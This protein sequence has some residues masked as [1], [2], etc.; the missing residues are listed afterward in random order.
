MLWLDNSSTVSS[1][2]VILLRTFFVGFGFLAPAMLFVKPKKMPQLK[3]LFVAAGIQIVRIAG[4]LYALFWILDAYTATTAKPAGDYLI[5]SGPK[6]YLGE[7]FY[8]YWLTPL[9]FFIATQLL[10][11]PKIKQNKIAVSVIALLVLLNSFNVFPI[12][13]SQ[14]KINMPWVWGWPAPDSWMFAVALLLHLFM[15]TTIV[16]TVLVA[17]GKL[18]EEGNK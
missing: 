6:L 3:K 8:I 7:H 12:L 18:K 2:I 10:W 5:S 9:I 14:Y 16:F 11:I 17:S 13:L 1:A 4:I 15:F